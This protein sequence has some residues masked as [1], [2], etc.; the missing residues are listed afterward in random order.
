MKSG[1]QPGLETRQNITVDESRVTKHMGENLGVYATPFLIRDIE[2]TCRELLQRYT[3]EGEDSVGTHIDIQHL[4]PALEGAE[5]TVEAC[6]SDVDRRAVSFEVTVR[7][8]YEELAR[9]SHSRFVV[10]TAKLKQRLEA[11]AAKMKG[12]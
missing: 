2:R 11:K 9:G 6:V 4:A 3:G 7:D 1:I 8:G 12:E 10:D 5:V